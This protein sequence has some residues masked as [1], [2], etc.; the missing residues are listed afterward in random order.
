M[1]TYQTIAEMLAGTDNM[2]VIRN[3]TRQ[4]DGTD[5]LTGVDWFKFLG[6]VASKVY[7]S[8]NGWINFGRG[9]EGGLKVNRRDQAVWYEWREEGTIRNENNKFLRIRWRGYS[10]YSTTAVANLLEFDVVL[11]STGDIILK[12]HTWPTANID[13]YNRLEASANVTFTPSQSSKEFSFIHQDDD[14]NRFVLENFIDE[15]FTPGYYLSFQP[16]SGY[17]TM[18]RQKIECGVTTPIS[19]NTFHK[20]NYDFI[21]WDTDEDADTVVYLPDEAVTDLGEDGDIIPL[22]AVWR[23]NWA[24]LLRD[25]NGKLYTVDRDAQYVQT[26]RQ[27]TGISTLNASAFYENGFQFPPDSSVLIDLYRPSVCKWSASEAP[28]VNANVRAIPIVPLPQLIVFKATTPKKAIRQVTITGDD[29]TL[30]N[31]SFDGG[32]TWW[33]HTGSAWAQVTQDGDGSAR[34][35][36]EAIP[37]ADWAAKAVNGS[38]QFRCWMTAG[39]WVNR[40]WVM[41]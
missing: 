28:Q 32:E 36:M 1:A 15:V 12:I 38:L 25:G 10:A 41:Y 26:R 17:G 35:V 14:G 33:K 40:I 29:A 19:A 34:A 2:T 21:G 8:G 6:T 22:Y 18:K 3:G 31:A 11:C 30:W 39:G 23:K 20:Q 13:G 16:S 27:L 37:A 4:D 7:V 9:S 24:W 5:T